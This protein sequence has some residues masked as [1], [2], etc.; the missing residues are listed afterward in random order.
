MSGGLPQNAV[1]GISGDS[2]AGAWFRE[3]SL[4]TGRGDPG[5]GALWAR[6]RIAALGDQERRGAD[7]AAIR[8]SIIDTALAH[9]LVSRFTSLVAVDKTPVRHSND[10]LKR[11]R[12]PNLMPRGQS[13]GVIFGFPATATNAQELRRRGIAIIAVALLLLLARRRRPIRALAA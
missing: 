12:V 13:A 2:T 6:A 7:G 4:A 11:E 9:H 8:T 1:V 10:P 3:L 5:I